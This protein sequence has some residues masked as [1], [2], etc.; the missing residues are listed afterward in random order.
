MLEKF[1]ANVLKR[2]HRVETQL[3]YRAGDLCGNLICQYFC[4]MIGDSQF[5][6]RQITSFSD[7][8]HYT[9]N[10]KKSVRGKF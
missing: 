5:F 9:K 4:W 8:F 1:R 3:K 6:F 2:A 7:S 10:Q